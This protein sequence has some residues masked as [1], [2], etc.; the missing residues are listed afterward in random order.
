M[1]RTRPLLF[2]RVATL[3]TACLLAALGCSHGKSSGGPASTEV[4]DKRPFD[5]TAHRT[6]K[7]SKSLV[8]APDWQPPPP[9]RTAAARPKARVQPKKQFGVPTQALAARPTDKQIGDHTKFRERLRP[10]PGASSAAETDALAAAL[11]QAQ[12]DDRGVDALV[13]FV[14]D[15]PNSR[16]APAVHANI[17]SVS[18]DTGYFQDALTHWKAAWDGAKA[19]TDD[20]STEMANHA[21]AEYAK[22]NA[23]IG[24][25]EELEPL[26]EEAKRREMRDDARVKITSASEGLWMMKNHPELSFRCGPYAL[27]SVA[28]AL[29]APA[30][31]RSQVF[32]DTVESPRTGFSIPEV[33]AMSN[34]L[35][36]A[37]Q[38]AKRDP[39]A[40]VIVPA[41]VHWKVGHFGA[42][43]RE[44]GGSF[45]MKDPTFV[46]E[47]W[48]SEKAIDEEASGYFLVPAGALPGGWRRATAAETAGFYGKGNTG[49]IDTKSTGDTDTG[50]GGGGSGCGAGGGP[51][52]LPMA[53]YSFHVLAASLHIEDTPV[54]YSAALGPDVRVRLAYNQR[55]SGQPSSIDYTSFGPQFV[56]NWVSYVVDNTTNT[57]ANVTLYERGGGSSIHSS[58]NTTTQTFG[59]DIKTGSVLQRLTANTYKRVYPDGK[60]HY[61]EQYIG[62]TGTAR[63][64]FLSRVVDAQGNEATI[65]YDAT[66]QVG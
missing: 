32:L 40:P 52:G 48:M 20:V 47:T 30:A 29:G 44:S 14:D 3:A 6:P 51:G 43:V 36:V 16:W 60:E 50:A 4:Q 12:Q 31:K 1:K 64:V 2:Q 24:R 66:T 54:G 5:P 13:R 28:E 34:R 55:E 21:L 59:V 38:I 18:Y 41:V 45:L 17:A 37:L 61:Y 35:G 11:G 8:L 22:M 65:D 63:K 53:T 10:V 19:G 57:S 15:Y 62:T 56:S 23:R 42:L 27:V 58:F 33:H 25:M 9:T 39:G 26:I 46:N 7:A 49:N